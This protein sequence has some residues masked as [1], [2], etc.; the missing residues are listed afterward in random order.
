[1]RLFISFLFVYLFISPPLMAQVCQQQQ[2]QDFH[3]ASYNLL[4]KNVGH[5]E[6][7]PDWSVRRSA[8]AQW[9]RS[10]NVGILGTQE[11]V[12]TMVNDL[13]RA[14]PHYRYVGERHSDYRATGRDQY[15][16]T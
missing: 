3:V 1:M 6:R 13:Q 4:N 2:S 5:A 14:L 16:F 7:Y 15:E 12:D 11:G 10:Q 9:V 8:I